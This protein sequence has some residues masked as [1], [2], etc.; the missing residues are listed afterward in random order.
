MSGR[1]PGSLSRLLSRIHHSA[2][3]HRG[4]KTWGPTFS[5]WDRMFGTYVDPAS[6]RLLPPW[7]GRK[8]ALKRDS[9]H[10]TGL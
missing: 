8:G 1:L 2:T 10:V 5:L 6:V 4:K 9:T 7:F 3:V